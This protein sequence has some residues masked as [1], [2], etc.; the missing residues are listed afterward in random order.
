SHAF[1]T[2][3]TIGYLETA[4]SR[5]AKDFAGSPKLMIGHISAKGGGY[6]KPHLSHQSGRD[7]DIGYYYVGGSRWYQRANVQNL[8]VERTWALVRALVTQTDV[9]MLLI[10]RSIQDLL[11]EH[12][13]KLGEDKEWLHLV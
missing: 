7:V 5:V 6:L 3:E 13:E 12:A 4:I 9:E 1:G 10:D 8:D 11:M 2:D